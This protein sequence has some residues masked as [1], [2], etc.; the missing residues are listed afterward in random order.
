MIS[1]I[2][3]TF[4]KNKTEFIIYHNERSKDGILTISYLTPIKLEWVFELNPIY[5]FFFFYD[6]D[7]LIYH[8]EQNNDIIKSINIIEHNKN[9]FNKSYL[10]KY[11]DKI[12][13]PVIS[14]I[15]T[16]SLMQLIDNVH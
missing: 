1:I 14:K 4:L 8:M 9:L 6:K 16:N 15:F 12:N 3:N 2:E 13:N 7:K 11:L 5:F 10:I